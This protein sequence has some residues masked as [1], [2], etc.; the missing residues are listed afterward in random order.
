[1]TTRPT[2]AQI[3]EVFAQEIGRAGGKVSDRVQEEEEVFARGVLAE[4][5]EIAPGDRSRGGVA[6]RATESDIFVHPYVFRMVCSNGAIMAQATQ[7]RQISREQWGPAGAEVVLENLREG[8][9]V[10]CQED[11]FVTA[12][13]QMRS[14]RERV[15]DIA[16][17]F[18]GFMSTH[19]GTMRPEVFA[20]ILRMYD[21]AG[22]SSA[23]GLMNAVTAVARQRRDAKTKWRLEE[24]GGAIATLSG[25]PKT[26]PGRARRLVPVG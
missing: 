14:A 24:L 22:D 25:R 17:A 3:L 9:R 19:R 5:I 18:S 10:C 1:M 26:M 20:Q 2:V 15:A 6:L 4:A 11:A 23:Y 7:T 12:A 16:L 8:I 13:N 21:R